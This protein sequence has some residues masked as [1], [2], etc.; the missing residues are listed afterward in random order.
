MEGSYSLN[1]SCTNCDWVGNVTMKKGISL[2]MGS[3]CPNC[4]C[5]SLRKQTPPS[6]LTSNKGVIPMMEPPMRLN[7]AGF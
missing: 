7:G 1:C 6:P 2:G 5:S 4:G 3:F